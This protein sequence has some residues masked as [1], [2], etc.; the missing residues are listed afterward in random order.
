MANDDEHINWWHLGHA[1][2]LLI[3]AFALLYLVSG[4]PWIPE[5]WIN[6]P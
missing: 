6:G 5:A 3:V 2:V 4:A 1:L